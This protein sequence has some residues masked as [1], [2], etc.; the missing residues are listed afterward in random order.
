MQPEYLLGGAYLARALVYPLQLSI[1]GFCGL[2]EKKRESVERMRKN[3]DFFRAFFFA[4]IGNR[5]AL[6]IAWRIVY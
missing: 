5:E 2:L 4:V 6:F 1:M 3:V